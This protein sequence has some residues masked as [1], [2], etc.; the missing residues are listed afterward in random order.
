MHVCVCVPMCTH[1]LELCVPAY[2]FLMSCI[3]VD[4]KILFEM[5]ISS[6]YDI[7]CLMGS[8]NGEFHI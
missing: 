4:R 2:F 8:S 3:S 5:F 1:M 7:E 6:I